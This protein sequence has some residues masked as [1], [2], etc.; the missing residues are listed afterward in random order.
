MLAIIESKG[1]V[2]LKACASCEFGLLMEED[3]KQMDAI[4][5]GG[6]QAFPRRSIRKSQEKRLKIIRTD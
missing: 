1:V 3:V 6:G 2:H 4:V 5:G